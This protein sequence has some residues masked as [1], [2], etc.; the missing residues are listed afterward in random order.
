MQRRPA[1]DGEQHIFSYDAVGYY[2]SLATNMKC[3]IPMRSVRSFATL[4]RSTPFRSTP[5][6]LPIMRFSRS[7]LDRSPPLTIHSLLPGPISAREVYLEQQHR[8]LVSCDFARRLTPEEI[9]W[10]D[11]FGA[12]MDSQEVQESLSGQAAARRCGAQ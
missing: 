3:L 8:Y 11:V 5:I 10:Q 7:P 9:R 1:P 12:T 2:G 4:F 6:R